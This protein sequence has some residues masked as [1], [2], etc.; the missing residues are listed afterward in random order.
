MEDTHKILT[1]AP[2]NT[3]IDTTHTEIHIPHSPN[4]I[5]TNRQK[6]RS[7]KHTHTYSHKDIRTLQ[8]IHTYTHTHSL[9]FITHTHTFTY[10]KCCST[11]RH[12]EGRTRVP[13]HVFIQIHTYAYIDSPAI[14][15]LTRMTSRSDHLHN[16]C[17]YKHLTH[18]EHYI[19]TH[20][21]ITT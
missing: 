10:K 7:H 21:H 1:H 5:H 19:R 18:N 2:T 3:H 4:K 12:N 9:I 16:T 17:K 20:T 8:Y 14:W 15:P 6:D 11:E 13:I